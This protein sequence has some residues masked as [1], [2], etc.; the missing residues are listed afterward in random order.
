MT[1]GKWP[2]NHIY[3]YIYIYA[4]P[5]YAPLI[6]IPKWGPERRSRIYIYINIYTPHHHTPNFWGT[7]PGC[8]MWR[9]V[10]AS[11]D[12]RPTLFRCLSSGGCFFSLSGVSPQATQEIGNP[13]AAPRTL[14]APPD[15]HRSIEGATLGRQVPFGD[16][17]RGSRRPEI[18]YIYIYIY[19][20]PSYAPLLGTQSW[21]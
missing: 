17:K 10:A 19:A 3:I 12:G 18:T 9:Y 4:A 6:L 11:C 14:H 2:P 5:S 16:P 1:F 20:A 15:H 21:I 8:R 13:G 7:K